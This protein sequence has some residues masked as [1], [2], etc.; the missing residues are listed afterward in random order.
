MRVNRDDGD[1]RRLKVIPTRFC[2]TDVTPMIIATP[3]GRSLDAPREALHRN[4]SNV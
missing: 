2:R 3:G 1:E 4:G